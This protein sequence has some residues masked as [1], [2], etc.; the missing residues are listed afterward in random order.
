[1][2]DNPLLARLREEV[3]VS[4]TILLHQHEAR[5]LL[6]QIERLE[7]AAAKQK[8]ACNTV[9]QAEADAAE[10]KIEQYKTLCRRA[11][12]YLPATFGVTRDI[13]NALDG[14]E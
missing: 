5:A 7:E 13:R 14:R 12:V 10:R 4:R 2:T 11:L 1:M 8:E 9:C 3:P 6:D